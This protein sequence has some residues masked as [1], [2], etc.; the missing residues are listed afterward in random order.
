M[1]KNRKNV[2]ETAIVNRRW[3]KSWFLEE[4]A[5]KKFITEPINSLGPCA[6]KKYIIVKWK[7]RKD[8]PIEKS[9]AKKIHGENSFIVKHF[10][11]LLLKKRGRKAGAAS[12]TTNRPNKRPAARVRLNL[13]I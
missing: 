4:K 7:H 9:A 12:T 11:F 13:V 10:S 3:K 6:W 5:E 1:F 8:F 2:L